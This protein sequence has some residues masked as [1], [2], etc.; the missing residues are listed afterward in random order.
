MYQNYD[1]REKSLAYYQKSGFHFVLRSIQ[2]ISGSLQRMCHLCPYS[3]YQTSPLP[4]SNWPDP[5]HCFQRLTIATSYLENSVSIPISSLGSPVTPVLGPQT[6]LRFSLKT[7]WMCS[8]LPVLYDLLLGPQNSF[9]CADT[10]SLFHLLHLHPSVHRWLKINPRKWVGD[11]SNSIP[12]RMSSSPFQAPNSHYVSTS[13]SSLS[14]KVK[15]LGRVN[16]RKHMQSLG[17]IR[18]EYVKR[19]EEGGVVYTLDASIS[20]QPKP[21]VMSRRRN[22]GPDWL[23]FLPEVTQQII[24][25]TSPPTHSSWHWQHLRFGSLIYTKGN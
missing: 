5:C 25:Q 16:G 14:H 7:G 23:H 17:R 11:R 9:A 8:F 4:A 12:F 22:N 6:I 18:W 20:A 13:P 24:N 3:I 10:R 21:P 1:Y 2:I 15:P 19:V